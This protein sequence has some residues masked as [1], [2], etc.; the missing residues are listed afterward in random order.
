VEGPSGLDF[1]LLG[2]LEAW[3]EDTRVDVG[4]PKQRAVLALLLLHRGEVV[5][6]DRI[7][8]ELWGERP[9]QAATKSVQV[10]VSG[11]RKALG[12]G[13]L[14]TRG[15]GYVLEGGT[16]DSDRFEALLAEGRELLASGD[17]GKAASTLREALGLWRG[18]ALADFAYEAFAREATARLEE[19]RLAALEE[20]VDA[21]LALGRHA[22]LVAELSQLV[23]EHPLRE[24]FRAQL[25]LALYRSGRQAEA[26]E[27]YRSGRRELVEHGLEPGPSLRELEESILRQ[28]PDLG[29][30]A[31]RPRPVRRRRSGLLIAAGGAALLA[32]AV[33]AATVVVTSD[34]PAVSAPLTDGVANIAGAD[35]GVDSFTHTP[36]IPGNV[37]VGAGAVW[38]LDT[39]G[40]GKVAKIA[41]DSGEVE[42]RFDAGHPAVEVAA[43]GGAVWVGTVGGDGGTNAF[44]SVSRIDERTGKVTHVTELPGGG[45]VL[46]TAGL[47]R[48]AAGAGA[49][50]AVNPD[51]SVSRIDLRTGELVERIDTE[52]PAWTIAAGREGVWYLS[53]DA[54]SAVTRIDPRTNRPG[55][56]IEVGSELLWGVAVGAGSVWATSREQGLLWR[57]EPGRHP[58]SRSIDVGAGVTAVA[59]GAGA[60]WTGNYIDGTVAR[61]DPATNAVTGRTPVDA[62]QAVAAGAGGAWVSVAGRSTGGPLR[63]PPCG[64]VESGGEKPDVLIA[65]D[66]PLQGPLSADPRAMESAIRFV[67]ERHGFRAG[68]HRVG[69]QSCD[70]STAETGGFEFR[71]CA[72]N[73][74]A[75]AHA[76]QLVAVIGPYSSFCAEVQLPILNRAPGGPVATISPSNTGPN[77][78]RG[79]PHAIDR[80]E[81][82]IY[83][84]T[85]VRHYMRLAPREDLQGVA[86]AQLARQ[87][88][89]DRVALIAD[90][91]PDARQTWAD[92]F[93]RAVRRLGMKDDLY[94]F[95]PEAASYAGLAERVVRAGAQGAYIVGYLDGGGDRLVR[96]LRKAGG[97]D[98]S[99]HVVDAFG[100]VPAVVKALGPAAHGLYMSA[101]DT[102]P[103]GLDLSP[104]GERFV[105]DFGYLDNP[106]P[107]VLPAAQAAESVL[108]AIAGSDGTRES[109]LARLRATRV[110]DS[111]LP[112]FRLDRYGDIDPGRIPIFRITGSTPAGEDVFDQ[113]EGAVVDR[114]IDVPLRE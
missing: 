50:W 40:G 91:D 74:N 5:S 57:I 81:P 48:L 24:G 109:V 72:A 67:L 88:G 36:T 18:P 79:G 70:V 7:V 54:E 47:P 51:G 101:T 76:R 94:G 35:D 23:A 8:D 25:M 58:V 108:D 96:A 41:A 32:A 103:D 84:P 9:P 85:G 49:V 61:V 92:P 30:T 13:S 102:P 3:R 104:A 31:R 38:A 113:F 52:T 55:Q 107:Y 4:A 62:P 16:V 89:H 65:S 63:S 71:T 114:V 99:I 19:L 21:D 37:A 33:A 6:T 42:A 78:T 73:A 53:L 95:D 2:P 66:L 106:T 86:Q 10:Y 100:T 80:G 27:A 110:E 105:R 77:L 90:P 82:G 112:S 75:Y 44:V 93:R 69:Y 28:D 1:R 39:G 34:D 15:H 17:A 97:E 111:I 56:T 26:L 83:Y 46:P 68:R 20:R 12:D 22:D 60:V 43:G 59:F 14:E 11:L 98:L 64:P 29:R 87:L 45:E